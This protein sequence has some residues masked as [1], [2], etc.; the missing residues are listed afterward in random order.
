MISGGK[1]RQKIDSDKVQARR[2]ANLRFSRVQKIFPTLSAK[3][4]CSLVELTSFVPSDVICLVP[5]ASPEQLGKFF[6]HVDEI[7]SLQSVEKSPVEVKEEVAVGTFL[8]FSWVKTFFS[9]SITFYGERLRGPYLISFCL[10]FSPFE[11]LLDFKTRI[12]HRPFWFK[13]FLIY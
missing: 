6:D 1:P 12:L 11:K 5:E 4:I 3:A 13:N 2:R 8:F 10:I 9:R 7:L